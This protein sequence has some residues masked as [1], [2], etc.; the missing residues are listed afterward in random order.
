MKQLSCVAAG[1]LCLLGVVPAAEPA[2]K[3]EAVKPPWQRYLQGEDARK[4]AEQEK[5]LAQLQE[6]GL[7][8]TALKVAEALTELRSRVQGADHWQT[9][10]ARF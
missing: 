1:M 4:A 5:K 6:G 7:L 10:D 9:V 8:A 3:A 2:K